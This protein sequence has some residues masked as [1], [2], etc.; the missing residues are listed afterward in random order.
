MSQSNLVSISE[1]MSFTYLVH[2]VLGS[3]VTIFAA[4]FFSPWIFLLLV[5]FV[6]LLFFTTGVDID[7]QE[8][9]VRKYRGLFGCHWG[10]WLPLEHFNKV[11]LEEFVVTKPSGGFFRYQRTSSKTYDILLENRDGGIFELNDFFDYSKSE[12][13]FN[14]LRKLRLDSENKYA[15]QTAELIKKRKERR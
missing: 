15:I 14:E 10:I 12:K 8:R 1:G 7:G 11:I 13:C 9:R 4:I 6:P 5:L 3:V 2:S